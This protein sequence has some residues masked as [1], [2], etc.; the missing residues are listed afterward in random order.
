MRYS[1]FLTT[2]LATGVQAA[3]NNCED[4]ITRGPFAVQE[5]YR[6]DGVKPLTAPAFT[7]TIDGKIYFAFI[8][9]NGG[10]QVHQIGQ[11]PRP[12]RQ[13]DSLLVPGQDRPLDLVWHFSEAQG[14]QLYVYWT[15]YE[16]GPHR[17]SFIYRMIISFV[18]DKARTTIVHLRGA[19]QANR[20]LS[21]GPRHEFF[22]WAP[23]DGSAVQLVDLNHPT[24]AIDVPERMDH[25]SVALANGQVLFLARP[26]G[27]WVEVLLYNSRDRAWEK[28]W[29][30]KC[31][32][33]CQSVA[34]KATRSTD[35]WIAYTDIRDR[36]WVHSLRTEAGR[37]VEIPNGAMAG[38][39]LVESQSMMAV[40]DIGWPLSLPL[41]IL[42]GADKQVLEH[43]IPV[44]EILPENSIRFLTG[45]D[46]DIWASYRTLRGL[47]FYSLS[48]GAL[49]AKITAQNLFNGNW[50]LEGSPLFFGQVGTEGGGYLRILSFKNHK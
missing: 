20:V 14:L 33:L 1:F 40:L 30:Q 42:D 49:R 2:L 9:G 41:L 45:P 39:H 47:T 26:N 5:V 48:S 43:T 24:S 46:G 11:D 31:Q 44:E 36:V 23:S 38:L 28:V 12:L 8:D 35:L 15:A 37:P 18:G 34:L 27:Q 10:L 50:F 29:E 32:S 17:E 3:A 16:V 21:F 7:H 25:N 22:T 19:G 4:L 13:Y 6:L